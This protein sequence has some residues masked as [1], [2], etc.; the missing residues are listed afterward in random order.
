MESFA[1]AV[2]IPFLLRAQNDDGGW[3]HRPGFCSSV[4]PTSWALLA[5]TSVSRGAEL[6]QSVRRGRGWLLQTQLPDGSWPAAV[7][8][9]EGSWVTSLACLALQTQEGTQETVAR[10]IIWLCSSWPGEGG[11]WWRFRHRL[12]GGPAVVTHNYSLRG[13]SWTPGT[14]SWVEPT[15]AALILLRNIPEKLRPRPAA[16]R[17]Q[18]GEAMLFDRMCPGGGWNCGNPIVYGAAEGPQV[19]PTAWALLALQHER[20]RPEN[21]IS[22]AW[23]ERA[24]ESIQGPASLALAHLCLETYQRT[25]LPLEPTL[26]RFYSANRFFDSVLVMAWTSAALSPTR[27][28]LQQ[29]AP[30]AAR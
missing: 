17:M 16:H 12:V 19:I 1:Q 14:S 11:F 5:L 23:L 4:E 9:V 30:R 20:N 10:G 24:C 18:L 7:G 27:P 6:T 28:W 13:W 3:G 25:S 2:C 29:A 15:S 8:Q 22:L 26:Q 21:Q